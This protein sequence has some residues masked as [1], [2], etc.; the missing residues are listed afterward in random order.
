MALD[1]NIDGAI[2]NAHQIVLAVLD[3]WQLVDSSKEAEAHFVLTVFGAFRSLI[4]VKT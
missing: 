3:Y 1:N 2:R 4:Y